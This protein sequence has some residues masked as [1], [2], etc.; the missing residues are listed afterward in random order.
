MKFIDKKTIQIDKDINELDRLVI[1][2]IRIL[3]KHTIYV[4]VSGYVAILLGRSRTT[5]DVDIFI[6]ELSKENF[7]KLYTDLQNSGFWCLNGENVAELYEYLI[8][9][10]AVR[11]ALENQTIPNFEVKFAR[12]LLDKESFNDTLTAITKIGKI[13]ISSLERQIAFKR[14]F[15]KSDKDIEDASH[16]EKLFKKNIDN[17]RVY[18]YKKMIENEAAKTRKRQ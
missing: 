15:L 18:E 1:K 3:E 8:E 4:I 16:I 2:F 7:R 5:E 10:L 13:R 6:Q 14:Y 9:G 17:R 11:F 12:K